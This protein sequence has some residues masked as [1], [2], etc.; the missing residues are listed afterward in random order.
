MKLRERAGLAKGK[1]YLIVGVAFP[2]ESCTRVLGAD[3]YTI[4]ATLKLILKELLKSPAWG[5]APL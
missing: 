4:L 2:K 1:T 5:D 3:K